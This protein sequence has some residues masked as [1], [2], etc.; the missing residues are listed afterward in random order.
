MAVMANES[1]FKFCFKKKKLVDNKCKKKEN[2]VVKR[3]INYSFKNNYRI[4]FNH[5]GN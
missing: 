1:F 5:Y 4:F 3:I 2:K